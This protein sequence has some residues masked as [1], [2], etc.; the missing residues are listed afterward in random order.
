MATESQNRF[1]KCP[2]TQVTHHRQCWSSFNVAHRLDVNSIALYYLQ[3]LM[4]CLICLQPTQWDRL[5]R[6]CSKFSVREALPSAHSKHRIAASP[7]TGEPPRARH[8]Q[9]PHSQLGGDRRCACRQ[10][11][12][13]PLG[14][15]KGNSRVAF[16]CRNSKLDM[17]E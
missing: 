16:R 10:R 6:R 5:L 8:A 15:R 9:Q 17:N 4:N 11:P 12:V 1:G 13:Q 14:E 2:H 3:S 7:S